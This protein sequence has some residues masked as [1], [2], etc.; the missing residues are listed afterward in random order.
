MSVYAEA[1]QALDL[2]ELGARWGHV[3]AAALWAGVGWWDAW[4]L[5]PARARLPREALAHLGHL[6]RA[7]AAWLR[8]SSVIAAG[9]GVV[10]LFLVY[11]GSRTAY[12]TG[13][14]PEAGDWMAALLVL[15]LAVGAYDVLAHVRG[16]GVAAACALVLGLAWF[17]TAR[18]G[19]SAR[20]AYVHAGALL[21]ACMGQNV[22]VRI[23]PAREHPGAAGTTAATAAR[24]ARHNA[25]F[26][27]PAIVLMAGVGQAGLFG[28]G[29][30]PTLAVILAASW[31]A[32]AGLDALSRAAASPRSPS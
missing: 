6:E 8:W 12:L 11:Y 9:L 27:L 10:L 18:L 25:F 15:V 20:G 30:L 14:L 28:F 29:V 2:V 22:W 19:F 26:A 32:A 1:G 23:A 3:A 5:E 4:I 17:C 7:L 21:G 13:A 31:A 16:V 24:R